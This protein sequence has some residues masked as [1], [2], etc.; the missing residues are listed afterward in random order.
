MTYM[1]FV[2]PDQIQLHTTNGWLTSY[3]MACGYIHRRE[4]NGVETSFWSEHG[5]Y[6][7][8]THCFRG[9]GRLKWDTATTITEGRRLFRDH[10]ALYLEGKAA[11]AA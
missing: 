6:H 7:V 5:T 9:G 11:R 3:A 4:N 10:V 2:S 1:G 8:R